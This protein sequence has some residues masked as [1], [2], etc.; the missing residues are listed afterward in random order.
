M[1]GLNDLITIMEANI[2]QE[3][4]GISVMFDQAKLH[5]EARDPRGYFLVYGHTPPAAIFLWDMEREK[6]EGKE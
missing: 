1:D 6:A 3:E 5:W 2:I 4:Y